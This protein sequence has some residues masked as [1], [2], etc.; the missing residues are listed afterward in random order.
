MSGNNTVQLRHCVLAK[1]PFPPPPGGTA[2][3]G[4]CRLFLQVYRSLT[5]TR[6]SR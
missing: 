4:H 2:Q 3:L 6:H 5:M 1:A